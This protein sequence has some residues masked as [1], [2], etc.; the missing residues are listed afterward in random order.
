MQNL[1]LLY[2][3]KLILLIIMI[4]L[5]FS[6][7]QLF[8]QQLTASSSISVVFSNPDGLSELGLGENPVLLMVHEIAPMVVPGEPYTPIITSDS[9]IGSRLQYSVVSD[10]QNKRIVVYTNDN[11]PSGLLFVEIANDDESFGTGD[12][13]SA[14][15]KRIGISAT[16]QT[17]VE[18]IGTCFTGTSENDGP[19]LKYTLSDEP[20][21]AYITVCYAMVDETN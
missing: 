8:A 20:V 15:R 12:S 16:P 14:N 11:I 9:K 1:H 13:G 10:L 4:M 5:C 19:L 18:G 21:T 7:D 3:L 17:I 2:G 6:V